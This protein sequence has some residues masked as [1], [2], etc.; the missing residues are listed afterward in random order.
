MLRIIFIYNILLYYKM[1]SKKQPIDPICA[2]C[3]IIS[4]N[5]KDLYTKIGING[6]A[7]NIQEP[8]SIQALLRIYY[9]DNREDVFELFYLVTHLLAWFLVPSYNENNHDN[10]ENNGKKI[11]KNIDERFITELKKMIG[12]MCI[13]L[14]RLQNTYKTGN[15]VLSIQYYIN[16]MRDGLNGNFDLNRLPQCLLEDLDIE[17]NMKTKIVSIWNYERLHVVCDLY[18][19]CFSELKKN[20]NKKTDI[21]DGYLLSID[22]ILSVY[23]KEFKTYIKQ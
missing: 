20:M 11:I 1:T 15:V 12:Y 17:T 18:D 21:I 14:E 6:H 4:L 3:R 13:G 23:E 22:S 10:T 16:L 8:S 2:L 5:F 19:N 9:G 7:I